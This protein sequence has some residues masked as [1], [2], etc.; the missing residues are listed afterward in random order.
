MFPFCRP[1]LVY[2]WQTENRRISD[3]TRASDHLL[4]TYMRL[5]E[6]HR[7]SVYPIVSQLIYIYLYQQISQI[8]LKGLQTS[9]SFQRTAT[10]PCQPCTLGSLQIHQCP[11]KGRSAVKP[12]RPLAPFVYLSGGGKVY[13]ELLHQEGL[14]KCS[15]LM[16]TWWGYS[17][18]RMHGCVCVNPLL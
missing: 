14:G 8:P 7:A 6:L 10:Q 2:W 4:L 18:A 16:W 11:F 13:R 9:N 1:L 17:W 12:A 15:W 5:H 3:K